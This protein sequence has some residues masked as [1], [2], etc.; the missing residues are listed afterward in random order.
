MEHEIVLLDEATIGKIAAG[1]VVERPL[2]VIKELIENSLDAKSKQIIIEIRDGGKTYI[3]VT[4]DG[5]GIPSDQLDK[6]FLRHSTSKLRKIE[7][8]ETLYTCGF[9]GEALSSVAAVSKTTL[10]TR[11]GSQEYAS[12]RII[13]G[14]KRILSEVSGSQAGTTLIVENLFFNVPAREKFMKSPQAE[15][16]AIN[17]LVTRYA[18]GHPEI[19][20]KLI[21]NYKVMLSTIGDG[22]L[23][24]AIRTVYGKDVSDKMFFV[25]EYQ[26]TED[27]RDVIKLYGYFSKTSLYQANRRMQTLLVNGR[28]VEDF[29]IS[30][31][32]ENA[33]KALIPIGKFPAFVFFVEVHPSRVDFNIHP[34]K[35]NIKYDSALNLEDRIYR[36]V[37]NSLL[38]KSSNLIPEGEFFTQKM[39]AVESKEKIR[40]FVDI[41]STTKRVEYE[42]T[43][44]ISSFLKKM[45][46]GEVLHSSPKVEDERTFYRP[47]TQQESSEIEKYKQAEKDEKIRQMSFTEKAAS[48]PLEPLSK[49]GIDTVLEEETLYLQEERTSEDEGAVDKDEG[50]LDYESL[51][52]VGQVFST[53]LIMTREEKMYLVD[54]HAAHERVLFE[55]YLDMVEKD[56]VSSQ[57]LLEHIHLH[58]DWEDSQIVLD[59]SELIRKLGFDISSFGERVFAIRGV[60]VMFNRNQTEHF[61]SEVIELFREGRGITEHE[62]FL[63]RV[64]TKA[65]RA[66]IKANDRMTDP[67]AAALMKSLNS[68]N[69][70]YTCPH[71]RPIFI[72]VKKYDLEKMFKRINA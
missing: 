51:H 37:R 5:I 26:E 19:K 44:P 32:V 14:G 71:G 69:N 11:T 62:E 49:K 46:T 55:R 28:Y 43:N 50:I 67:E 6:V 16:M 39:S 70:K 30:R 36:L 64:A 68:C 65:C 29:S 66:A 12:K 56:K 17:Q 8:L 7:D 54:Q 2:A 48:T 42:P 15:A 72:E 4:D 57:Q 59:N 1:E 27:P 58:L 24:H 23:E 47:E 21:N 20:F 13:E 33:Y 22:R 34:N 25:E 61:F 52:Y 53:Y 3:R 9:R 35:L 10:I 41:E 31:T 40:P 18:V 45:E 60:P 38:S 63:H